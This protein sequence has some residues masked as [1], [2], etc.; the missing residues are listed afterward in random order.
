MRKKPKIRY[1]DMAIYVDNHIKEPDHDVKRVFDYLVMLAYMLSVKR[2]FF[3][4]E[5]YYDHFANY[6]AIIVYTRMTTKRQYLPETDPQYLTPVKSC[7]NYMKQILY[8]RKCSFIAE[9]FNFT[10]RNN[11]EESFAFKD[12]MYD[13]V[14][15]TPN[16][17][18][19]CDM[20]VYL[21]TIDRIIKDHIY[22]GV[23]G[24]DKVLAWKLYTS[25]L[26]S[27][28][29]NFTLSNKNKLKLQFFKCTT[30]YDDWLE[31][32]ILEESK[33]APVVYDLEPEYLDY[34][35][36][37]L[38]KIKATII[39]D[40]RELSAYYT[41]PDEMLED[42]FMLETNFGTEDD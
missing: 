17:L 4:K 12:H 40:I 42:L 1:V 24:N 38:Q 32:T 15:S 33:T 22:N 41:Y 28:V 21:S 39:K 9:E 19:V 35:A 16:S 18:L 37:M 7:L 3:N 27:L 8:A 31:K 6:M 29:R 11:D 23:Y 14:M 34:I 20:K 36:V 26:I 25:C 2:R 30:D 13:S 5:S 10:T